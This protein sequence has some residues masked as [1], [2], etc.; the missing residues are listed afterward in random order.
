MSSEAARSARLPFLVRLSSDVLVL[1]GGMGTQLYQQGMSFQDCFETANLD[2]TEWVL[3]IHRRFLDAGAEGVQT[4]TFG[5]NRFR[6]AKHHR[7]ED[8]EEILGAAAGLARQAAGPHRYVLGAL[9]PLGVEM[10]PIGRLD[11]GEVRAAFCEL[12]SLLSDQVDAF[13]LETF[14]NVEELVEA[15]HGVREGSD[16]P[17]IASF[18]VNDQGVTLHGTPA[19]DGGARLEQAGADVVGLNCSTG[20]RAILQSMLQVA[21]VTDK[22]LAARPNAGMP[23]QID[24]RLFYE[25]NPDYFARFARRFLQAGGRLLGG[26]CGTTPEHIRAMVRAARAIG[27]QV[28][29]S[30][31]APAHRQLEVSGPRPLRPRPLA[32]R[33]KLARELAEGLCPVSI[34][35][36]PPRTPDMSGMLEAARKIQDAGATVINIPDGP[37]ASARISNTATAVILERELGVETL[38]HMCCR[39]R[40]LLGMQSD[41]MGYS[42][43]G[44]H[45]LLIVTGDPPYQGNYP[46]VT[47]VFDVD[48]IGLCNIVDN[49]N[50]GLDLGGN[51]IGAPTHFCFGAAFNPTALDLER[52]LHRFGWKSK[53]GVNF[54]IT[55]PIFDVEGFCRVLEELPDNRPPILAGV[56]PLRSLRNAEF[57]N[58]EVPG[59]TIPEQVLDRIRA[60]DRKGKAAAE[61]VV[62]ARETVEALGDAVEGFQIAAPFNKPEAAIEVMKTVRAYA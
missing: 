10:E 43:I 62:L 17:V 23:R 38:P 31:G 18:T 32:E 58:A 59:V 60:A 57:L 40:N 3:E 34:E 7:E 27:A 42:A 46:N 9:G 51:E 28:R 37:R 11:R 20:P 13:A 61:G 41:L 26:C 55:Q 12:A 47:A 49:M 22:P 54:F 44:L 45:N 1:D 33:S 39:D 30:G 35:L 21:E 24:G 25:S 19:R 29:Q 15:I 16:K 36:V 8:L 50:H 56:W 14:S 6:L 53:A 5:A 52:E 4:N 2:R 48:A